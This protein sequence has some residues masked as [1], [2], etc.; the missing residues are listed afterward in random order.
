[1]WNHNFARGNGYQERLS[2]ASSYPD[3]ADCLEV[4]VHVVQVTTRLLA[5]LTEHVVLGILDSE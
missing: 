5:W 4:I 3:L 1:M 2:A